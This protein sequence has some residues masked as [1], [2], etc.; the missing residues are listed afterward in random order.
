MKNFS[1][2]FLMIINLKICKGFELENRSG[3]NFTPSITIYDQ[4]SLINFQNCYPKIANTKIIKF[5]SQNIIWVL[6]VNLE[7][8]AKD[9]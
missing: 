1:I 7:S 5:C 2:L 6:N 4:K 3:C 8:Q 9:I